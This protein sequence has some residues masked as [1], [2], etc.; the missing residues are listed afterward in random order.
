MKRLQEKELNRTS[1]DYPQSRTITFLFLVI[2]L[3]IIAG[4]NTSRDAEYRMK[5]PSAF[6]VY[7][8]LPKIAPDNNTLLFSYFSVFES[9]L[10][11]YN[12]ATGEIRTIETP[13][14]RHC[15]HPS[16]SRDGKTIVF[17]G[18]NDEWH[19]EM[20]F[21][22]M[23]K[24]IYVIN[25]DG[26]GLRQVSHFPINKRKLGEPGEVKVCGNASFSPDGQRII[27]NCSAMQRKKAPPLEGTM[28]S[29]WDFYEMDITTGKERKLTDYAFYSTG[30]GFYLND[31]KHFIFNGNTPLKLVAQSNE[32][33]SSDNYKKSQI[34]II[35]GVN[36]ILTPIL[37]Y[38]NHVSVRDVAYDDTIL[39]VIFN[40]K[41]DSRPTDPPVCDL[42]LRRIDGS[43]KRV[44]NM[45]IDNFVAYI[46]PD[47]SRVIFR[48]QNEWSIWLINSDGSD[49]RE[50]TIPL[51]KLQK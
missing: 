45:Q 17:S 24:N 30:V 49:L 41:Q 6:K 14:I 48:K 20:S 5:H 36:N 46:S 50:V 26:T 32:D 27:Y 43:I 51:E 19:G 47:G 2:S 44:T 22:I 39:L 11:T 23:N 28:F 31:G 4:C 16:Y 29:W 9:K 40:N 42:F 37:Q 33:E 8:A 35:D 10:A 18:S 15:Y 13:G 7:I 34:F 1:R 12:L 3:L 38:D 25:S 21:Q